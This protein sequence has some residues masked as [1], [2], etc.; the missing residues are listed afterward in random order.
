MN[1]IEEFVERSVESEVVPQ[2]KGT[3]SVDLGE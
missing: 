3:R 2:D 1:G